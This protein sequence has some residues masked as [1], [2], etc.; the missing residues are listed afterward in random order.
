MYPNYFPPPLFHMP[1]K[2]SILSF[3][4]PEL[5]YKF[6]LLS[7]F[8][9]T[10]VLFFLYYNQINLRIF[11]SCILGFLNTPKSWWIFKSSCKV[12]TN[13]L[14][15]IFMTYLRLCLLGKRK[16]W[17]SLSVQ[18]KRNSV[19][20]RDLFIDRASPFLFSLVTDWTTD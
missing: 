6:M 8:W 1:F 10:L 5:A 17:K 18:D 20:P 2:H 16:I 15:P 13:W 9:E 3:E 19:S 12:M 4:S 7:L 14:Q 11:C